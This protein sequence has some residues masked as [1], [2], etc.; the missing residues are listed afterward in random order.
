MFCLSC[1]GKSTALPTGAGKYRTVA[2]SQEAS[3]GMIDTK[4]FV[5]FTK[6]CFQHSC[7]I[8][9]QPLFSR[10]TVLPAFAY[11]RRGK[12]GLGETILPSTLNY[13][14]YSE[15]CLCD[16]GSSVHLFSVLCDRTAEKVQ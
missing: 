9:H 4:F 6:I 11:C 1:E 10:V 15:Y 8:S 5:V 13:G 16:L 2:I 3:R 7:E 12:G 14:I